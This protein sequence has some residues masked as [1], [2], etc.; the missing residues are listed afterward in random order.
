MSWV[1]TFLGT[2]LGG[3]TTGILVGVGVSLC[4][5]LESISRPQVAELGQLPETRLF[6]N[7]K[8]Y[9]QAVT[10]PGIVVCRFDGPLI[11]TSKEHLRNSLNGVIARRNKQARL[12]LEEHRNSNHA[13]QQEKKHSLNNKPAS[14]SSPD[15]ED[16]LAVD[17][18]LEQG[19]V[20]QRGNSNNANQASEPNRIQR[21]NTMFPE[22]RDPKR[23]KYVVLDFSVVTNPNSPE[24][25]QHPSNHN[26]LNLSV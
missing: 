7:V 5:L 10:H 14:I 20:R 6:R 9:P 24:L 1:V 8:R 17:G 11:F 12:G 15:N 26:Y 25:P 21:S 19:Q 23:I 2:L 16:P 18:D 3:T 4:V 22:R 13:N